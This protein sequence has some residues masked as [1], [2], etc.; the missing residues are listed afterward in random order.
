[1]VNLCVESSFLPRINIQEQASVTVDQDLI[2][3]GLIIPISVTDRIF[4]DCKLD[5]TQYELDSLQ[6]RYKLKEANQNLKPEQQ[7][8]SQVTTQRFVNEPET[9]QITCEQ[10]IDKVTL[11]QTNPVTPGFFQPT[12]PPQPQLNS[13][14]K[15][16]IQPNQPLLPPQVNSTPTTNIT[17]TQQAP[18]QQNVSISNPTP[19]GGAYMNEFFQKLQGFQKRIEEGGLTKIEKKISE[20]KIEINEAKR[21]EE[22]K[23][24]TLANACMNIR[25]SIDSDEECERDFE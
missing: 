22:N 8:I 3:I 15:I 14:P 2:F 9:V 21:Q 12:P 23:N 18:Q 17:S 1:M 20:N 7:K 5:F 10:T 16:N 11:S 19:K 13:I 25:K 24:N 6:G 4:T